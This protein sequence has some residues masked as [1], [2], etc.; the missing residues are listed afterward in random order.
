MKAET[1]DELTSH[2]TL[3]LRPLAN[4]YAWAQSKGY[5]IFVVWL[6][7]PS[8][9]GKTTIA[10]AVAGLG[11]GARRLERALGARVEVGGSVLDARRG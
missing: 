7:G 8:G 9:V 4:V 5:V 6:Q 2:H 10:S 11:E 1:C 3:W